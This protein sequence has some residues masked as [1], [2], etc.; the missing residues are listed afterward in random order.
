MNKNR[1]HD[2]STLIVVLWVI[3][4]LTILIGSFAFDARIEARI[5]SYYR[6]RSKAS[7][8]SKSGVELSTM[9]MAKSKELGG[10]GTTVESA[11]EED[12]WREYALRLSRGQ[13]ITGLEHELGDGK[14][15]LDI[16]PEPGRRNINH[17]GSNDMEIEQNIERILEVGGITEDTGLWPELIDSLRD[18]TD[19]DDL[20]RANGAETEDYYATLEEP[21][22]A[23]NGPLDTVDEMLLIKNFNRTILYGGALNAQG[24]EIELPAEKAAAG[25][26][27]NGTASVNVETD[28]KKEPGKESVDEDGV[29]KIS[30]IQDL[31]TIY[32]DG[33][34]NVNAASARVLMTL[35]KVDEVI[36][37]AIIEEREGAGLETD[38]KESKTEEEDY[39]FR[40]VEDLFTRIPEVSQEIKP[41]ISTV[42]TIYRITSIGE[43]GGVRKKVWCIASFQGKSLR[44][45]RWREE[46]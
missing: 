5:I 35:S 34:I 36:A 1:R 19:K 24:E 32:G 14:I 33:K 40:S 2:G 6:K 26:A 22:M 44:I 46:E 8:L 42:S 11:V 20:S 15:I 16:V 31:L 23:K 13:A 43:V 18:W 17:L 9:L 21:Y 7:Y 45:M 30:G 38:E 37:G 3:G 41:Y 39:S 4:L 12:P 29:R 10:R 27:T 28:P 25:E